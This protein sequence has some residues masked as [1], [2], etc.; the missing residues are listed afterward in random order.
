MGHITD[1]TG[2]PLPRNSWVAVRSDFGCHEMCCALCVGNCGGGG[3]H[4]WVLWLWAFWGRKGRPRG[5][6]GLGLIKPF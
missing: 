4:F 5:A 3:V 1:L 2:G 6:A